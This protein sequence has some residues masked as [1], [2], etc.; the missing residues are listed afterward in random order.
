MKFVKK[1]K[2]NAIL[3]SLLG[4]TGVLNG[5]EMAANRVKEKKDQ[6]EVAVSEDY[7]R[8]KSENSTGNSFSISDEDMLKLLDDKLEKSDRD[9]KNMQDITAEVSN[10][11]KQEVSEVKKTDHIK[12][13]KDIIAT[14]ILENGL[15]NVEHI[16][17]NKMDSDYKD[18]I[19]YKGVT[20]YSYLGGDNSEINFVNKAQMSGENFKI[21]SEKAKTEKLNKDDIDKH[22]F[23]IKERIENDTKAYKN[24]SADLGI[25]SEIAY[26]YEEEHS[27]KAENVWLSPFESL[28]LD[29]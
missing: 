9:S 19:D 22:S 6:L 13:V 26:Q 28:T 20:N 15:V 21:L 17:N 10:S 23:S 8:R 12:E 14:N 4:I 29:S 16:K 5:G 25:A 18:Y 7:L 27:S 3:L 11:Y 2:K 24:Y 1:N